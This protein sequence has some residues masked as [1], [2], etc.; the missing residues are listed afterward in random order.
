MMQLDYF[1]GHLTMFDKALSVPF[2]FWLF[3]L[4]GI[5]VAINRVK[6]L[7]NIPF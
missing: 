5:T 4:N 2:S 3:R 6:N 1:I 7:M